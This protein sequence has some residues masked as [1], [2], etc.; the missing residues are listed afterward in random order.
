[1]HINDLPEEV[2]LLVIENCTAKDL[3]ALAHTCSHFA[4]I[5]KLDII[6][7]KLYKKKYDME[8]LGNV[9]SYYRLYSGLLHNHGWMIGLFWTQKLEYDGF[10]EVKCSGGVIQGLQVTYPVGKK[11]ILEIEIDQKDPKCLRYPLTCHRAKIR[12]DHI[13]FPNSIDYRCNRRISHKFKKK[14]GYHRSWDHMFNG[15]MYTR[16]SISNGKHMFKVVKSLRWPLAYTISMEV[17]SRY[18]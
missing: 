17:C 3:H 6:W 13:I 10:L 12:R 8:D 1:M 18:P 9:E 2:L 14:Y 15:Q 4:K 5:M 16:I 11:V 7:K